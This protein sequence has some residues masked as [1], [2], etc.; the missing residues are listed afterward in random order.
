M[1]NITNPRKLYCEVVIFALTGR[2]LQETFQIE[3]DVVYGICS[4]KQPCFLQ[5]LIYAK[6]LNVK[7]LLTSAKSRIFSSQHYLYF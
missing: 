6:A 5:L 2:T 3:V 7:L 4:S 1:E